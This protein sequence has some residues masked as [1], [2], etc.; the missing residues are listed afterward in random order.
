MLNNNSKIKILVTW[1]DKSLF[2]LPLHIH[3]RSE[4][5]FHIVSQGLRLMEALLSYSCTFWHMWP[6]WS[7]QKGKG[8]EELES[9]I[10]ALF[11]MKVT[12]SFTHS[13]LARTSNMAPPNCK[14]AGE[15]WG[16]LWIFS[17]K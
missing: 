10:L 2:L 1:G 15:L 4:I 11:S 7:P 17:D 5:L 8:E 13:T 16:S 9:H 3:H 14:V 6:P 12:Y